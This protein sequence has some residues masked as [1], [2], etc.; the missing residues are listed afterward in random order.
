MEIR[1]HLNVHGMVQGVGFRYRAKHMAD[2]M[3]LTGT[4]KNLSDGSVELEVQGE[5]ALIK[6][7]LDRLC[8][9]AS[10]QVLSIDCEECSVHAE[11]SFEIL[12]Y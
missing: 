2:A 3:A 8:N 4:V 9:S 6:E 1:Q 5:E 10:V 11:S 7:Y 12:D